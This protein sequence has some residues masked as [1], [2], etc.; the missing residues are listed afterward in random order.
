MPEP[1]VRLYIWGLFR[2]SPGSASYLLI[3]IWLCSFGDVVFYH[4]SHVKR[5]R[6]FEHAQNVRIRII[7][8]MR[9]VSSWHLLFNDTFQSV[10]WFHSQTANVL[11]RLRGCA[12]WSGPSLSAFARRHVF[13]WQ[14]PYTLL[15]L[16]GHFWLWLWVSF[17][18]SIRGLVY[19]ERKA[20]AP[21][22][23]IFFSPFWV[24]Q[25]PANSPFCIR[26]L[27]LFLPY[28]PRPSHLI[29]TS[30]DSSLGEESPGSIGTG[31][32]PLW[33]HRNLEGSA[34]HQHIAASLCR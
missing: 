10:Q 16:Y 25:D 21:L 3:R 34:N 2:M 28:P 14:G 26:F 24:E 5:K 23:I 11:I 19:S 12:G 15:C 20:F 27:F 7:M 13:A 1:L 32:Y 17:C 4:T 33:N 6:S 22:S 30:E 8:H 18:K 31:K 29:I 9:K